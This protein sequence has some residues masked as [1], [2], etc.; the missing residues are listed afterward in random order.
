MVSAVCTLIVQTNGSVLLTV[1]VRCGKP[2][3][4]VTVFGGWLVRYDTQAHPPNQVSSDDS[5]EIHTKSWSADSGEGFWS[6]QAQLYRKYMYGGMVLTV[7]DNI[8]R[9]GQICW[10]TVVYVERNQ[11]RCATRFYL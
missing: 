4:V 11:E 6:T 9:P 5:P 2:V 8:N 7:I 1:Q 10:L 3:S